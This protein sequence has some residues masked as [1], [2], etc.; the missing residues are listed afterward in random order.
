MKSISTNVVTASEREGKIRERQKASASNSTDS[1]ARTSARDATA[2]FTLTELLVVIAVIAVLAAL[3]L[4]SLS[5]SKASASR[6]KCVSNLRQLGIAGRMYWDDNGGNAFRW[7]GAATNGGQIFWFGWLENGDEGARRFDSSLGQ[8][9]PYLGGRGVEV[10]PALDYVRP[11]FKLKATG[12]AYGY[13]YNF[14]LSPPPEQPPVNIDQMAH[15]SALAF[16]ADA[17]QVNAFQFPASPTHPMLEEFYYVST[18]E[19]TAHFRH[20]K[21]SNVGFCDG[22]VAAEK[23]EVGSLDQRIL[24]ETLGRLRRGILT[25]TE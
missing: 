17:A 9:Y 23:P 8:L 12:A 16:L 7:R 4:P 1:H 13:G 3:L 18:N 2:A 19:S 21:M 25:G 20:A 22:H 10:C 14:Q 5:K 15:P 24:A 6:L 11:Q